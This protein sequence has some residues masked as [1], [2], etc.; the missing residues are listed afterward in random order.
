MNSANQRV[1]LVPA[2]E[3]N[4]IFVLID[5]GRK[6]C[7]VV[8]PGESEDVLAFIA[9]EGLTLTALLLTHHHADHIGGVTAIKAKFPQVPIYAPLKNKT[10]IPQGTHYVSDGDVLNLSSFQFRVMELP[11]HTLGHV[12][13]WEES[14]QWLFSGDVL[15]GLGCGRLFEGTPEQMYQSLSKIRALP[16]ET[17]IFCTHEYTETNLRFCKALGPIDSF[18]MPID[19][20]DFQSYEDDLLKRREQGQPSVPLSLK[21]EKRSNPFLL[22][23]SAQDFAGIREARNRF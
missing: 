1:E 12:A 3:D 10:Q 14:Q 4:Y 11:G 23:H 9:K 21:R 2:F 22:A 8:D 13:F 19:N 5:S 6:E 7:L 15:F 17:L 18:T 20:E 16:E